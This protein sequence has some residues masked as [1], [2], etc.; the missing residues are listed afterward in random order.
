MNKNENV[1]FIY[2][3]I[4]EQNE[5]EIAKKIGKTFLCGDVSVGA[6]TKK[7]S[8]LIKSSEINQFVSMYPD[9]KIIA[10]GVLSSMR[11][12]ETKMN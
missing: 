6:N 3:E 9:A 12:T 1:A 11:Y 7:F 2:S 8:K 4:H 5:K 10:E